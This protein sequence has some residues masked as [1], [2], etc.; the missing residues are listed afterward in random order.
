MG[1]NR[2]SRAKRDQTW[3]EDIVT[4]GISR[5]EGIAV[6]WIAGSCSP[7]LG[8]HL[9][10]ARRKRPEGLVTVSLSSHREP[11]LDRP[12][13]QSHRNISFGWRVPIAGHIGWP[14]SAP[15]HRRPPSE[16]V[17]QCFVHPILAI[18][19][20]IA[21]ILGLDGCY[22]NHAIPKPSWRSD[23]YCY[24]FI[25]NNISHIQ[26]PKQIFEEKVSCAVYLYLSRSFFFFTSLDAK[27]WH[28]G[29]DLEKWLQ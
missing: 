2:I 27:S 13:L 16:G 8:L 26:Y 9:N 28:Q 22:D 20:T 1:L 7:C 19:D 21:A 15:R 24:H 3:R 6:D 10:G 23:P 12:R 14:G 4:S 5:V 25:E 11:L 18:R 17:G 29:I